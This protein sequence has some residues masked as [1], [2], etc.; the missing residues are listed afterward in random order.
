VVNH[1]HIGVIPTLRPGRWE[2]QRTCL[3]NHTRIGVIPTLYGEV[4][5]DEFQRT[6][7]PMHV[8]G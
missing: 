2:H 5:N 6:K 8:C 7:R 4:N 1:V 3:G